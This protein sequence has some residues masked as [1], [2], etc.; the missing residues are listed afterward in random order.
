MYMNICSYM[1]IYIYICIYIYYINIYVFVHVN[2]YVLMYSLL[3]V[4]LFNG[5]ELDDGPDV[6]V[7][8]SVLH[9]VAIH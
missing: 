2:I 6:Q 7:C 4:T 5:S 3:L 9:C 1:Y 8:Y